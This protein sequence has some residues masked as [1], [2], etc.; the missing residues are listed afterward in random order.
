VIVSL[1]I[2]EWTAWHSYIQCSV[3]CGAGYGERIRECNTGNDDDCTRVYPGQHRWEVFAC[4]D[5]DCLGKFF[6]QHWIYE[7][8]RYCRKVWCTQTTMPISHA[9]L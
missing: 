8:I 9:E 5:G 4:N 1:Y 6:W 3:S 2:L 7:K